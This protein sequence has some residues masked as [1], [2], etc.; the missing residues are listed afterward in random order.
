MANGHFG[1]QTG[2]HLVQLINPFQYAREGEAAPVDIGVVGLEIK[3]ELVGV[4][5]QNVADFFEVFEVI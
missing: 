1:V 4:A 2:K 5:H 3:G